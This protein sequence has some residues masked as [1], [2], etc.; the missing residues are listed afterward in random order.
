MDRY[1]QLQELT[2]TLAESTSDVSDLRD[3]LAE[4]IRDTDTLLVQQARINTELQEDSCE[5][6]WSLRATPAP[7][8]AHRSPGGSGVGAGGSTVENAEG[9][10]TATFWNG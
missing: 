9:R 3:T 7:P 1:T 8:E 5:R 2:R 4:R 6:A 10:L